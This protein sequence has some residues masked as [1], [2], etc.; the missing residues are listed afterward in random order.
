MTFLDLQN[1]VC[2]L[3]IPKN[4]GSS[5]QSALYHAGIKNDLDIGSSLILTKFCRL[6]QDRGRFAFVW[7]PL[8]LSRLRMLNEMHSSHLR[9]SDVLVNIDTC[10]S[11]LAVIGVVRDPFDWIVSQYSY[12]Y[13]L[14]WH[15]FHSHCFFRDFEAFAQW[16]CCLGFESQASYFAHSP[17]LDL[18]KIILDFDCI[19]KGWKKF[20]LEYRLPYPSVL[21]SLNKGNPSHKS[22]SVY[23]KYSS[24][25]LSRIKSMIYQAYAEDLMLLR[26][27]YV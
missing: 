22:S 16:R 19:G 17:T 12:I 13:S 18:K 2:F 10:P 6:L 20:V 15:P 1:K 4:A 7:R 3:H 25:Q 11:D 9:L 27:V 23:S 14:R 5:V 26:R 8:G 21:P 24:L